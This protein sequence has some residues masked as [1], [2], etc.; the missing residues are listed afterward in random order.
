MH[1]YAAIVFMI[2]LWACCK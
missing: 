1:I 2:W